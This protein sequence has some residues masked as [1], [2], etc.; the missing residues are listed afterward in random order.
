LYEALEKEKEKQTITISEDKKAV[1][2]Q[3]KKKNCELEQ[4]N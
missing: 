3:K 4:L 2:L 1:C